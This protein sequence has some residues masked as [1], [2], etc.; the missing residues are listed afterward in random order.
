MAMAA[1]LPQDDGLAQA[2]N[3]D[4]TRQTSFQQQ[5]ATTRPRFVLQLS[6]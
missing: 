4:I 5:P 2:G 1:L 3:V 6:I